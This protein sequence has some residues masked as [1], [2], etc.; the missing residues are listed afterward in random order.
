[1]SAKPNSDGLT[2]VSKDGDPDAPLKEARLPVNIPPESKSLSCVVGGKTTCRGRLH[3]E[4]LD[5]TKERAARRGLP[6]RLGSFL[7][8]G[9]VSVSLG[10]LALRLYNRVSPSFIFYDDS[11]NRFRSRPHMWVHG[12]MTNSLGFLD[13]EP[14]AEKGNRFRILGIGD[15]FSWGVV[16]Y[17][18]NYLTVLEEVLSAR[19]PRVEVVNMG[20]PATGPPDYLAI[21][22]NEGLALDPDMVVLSFFVGNDFTERQRQAALHDRFYVVALARYAL[23]LRPHFEGVPSKDSPYDD[24]EPTLDEDAF[25]AVE[26]R[27]SV[28]Y[29][30]QADDFMLLLKESFEPLLE[31]QRVCSSR[32]IDLVVVLIPDELQVNQQLQ[33]TVAASLSLQLQDIDWARPNRMLAEALS[34]AGV[35]AV[36][37]LPRFAELGAS[38]RLYKP[39][40]THWNI[41]GNRLAA[42]LIA[43]ALAR[44][45]GATGPGAG[46]ATGPEAWSGSSD[47]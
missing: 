26:R 19:D 10:E 15:S 39:R 16:P 44:R 23:A 2:P 8:I 20:I 28:I 7:L 36:D 43:E 1:L 41:A 33:A 35:S 32:N 30:A 14:T 12:F 25:L 31:M 46:S 21:L 34:Q 11:Y 40:N 13:T 4:C 42:E 22:V 45:Y 3:T 9:V 38:Q 24:D 37:L 18:S 27:R 29:T 6:R 17:E 5:A 47:D